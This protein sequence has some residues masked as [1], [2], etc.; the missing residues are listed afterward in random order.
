MLENDVGMFLDKV[1]N[2]L[3]NVFEYLMTFYAVS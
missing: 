3:V 1:K 2:V